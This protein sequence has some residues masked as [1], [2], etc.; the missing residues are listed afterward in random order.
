MLANAA[1]YVGWTQVFADIFAGTFC[2]EIRQE[3]A[4]AFTRQRTGVQ[5]LG[6]VAT[7]DIVGE[8]AGVIIAANTVLCTIAEGIVHDR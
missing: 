2:L 6:F 1:P 8:A 7:I 4:W 3:L 5:W